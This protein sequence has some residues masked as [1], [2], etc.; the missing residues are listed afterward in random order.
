MANEFKI[1]IPEVEASTRLR[2]LGMVFNQDDK[3]YKEDHL[4]YA[5]ST[6]FDVFDYSLIQGERKG[7]LTEPNSIILS[8]EMAIKYFGSEALD[9]GNILGSSCAMTF[10]SASM[11]SNAGF[12]HR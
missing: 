5:D 12:D 1:S 3:I 2:P 9:K 10:I 8:E 11:L 6:F 4:M 7:S